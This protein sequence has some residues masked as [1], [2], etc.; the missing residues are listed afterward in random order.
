M[1]IRK[2]VTLVG[3][4]LIMW[5]GVFTIDNVRVTKYDKPPVFCISLDKE[6]S[7]YYGL[8]YRYDV[9]SNIRTG[10]LEYSL[11]IIGIQVRTTFTNLN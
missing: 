2:L 6:S 9:Y 8:G 10:E 4:V 3:A 1:K 7:R 5:L 11:W